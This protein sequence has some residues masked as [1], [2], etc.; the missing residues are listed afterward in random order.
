MPEVVLCE[1]NDGIAVFTLN[2][3]EKLTAINF[4]VIDTLM[5]LTGDSISA[6][7]AEQ[8]GLINKVVPHGALLAEAK[9]LARRIMEKSP[10]AVSATIGAVTRGLNVSIDE[11][12]AIEAAQFGQVVPS[13]DFH[14][15]IAA[16]LEKR[17]PRFI[18]R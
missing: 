7:R 6:E 1:I 11:G 4:A 9:A 8:I 12:L 5:A 3:P 13:E 17:S 16:F 18:G 14:E 2:R 15:G 10:L